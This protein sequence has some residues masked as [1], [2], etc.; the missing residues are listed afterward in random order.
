MA[1]HAP[2]LIARPGIDHIAMRQ[3]GSPLVRNIEKVTVAFL[4]LLIL[5]RGIGNTP[6]LLVVI[7]AAKKMDDD[8]FDTVGCL[9][10]EKIKGIMR[11]GEVTVHAVGH[12]SLFIVGMGGGLPGVVSE[13]N[14]MARCAKLRRGCPHHGEIGHAEKGK[15]YGNA[16]GDID[17]RLNDLLPGGLFL[18]NIICRFFHLASKDIHGE[19]QK[20]PVAI[21]NS[22]FSSFLST[23]G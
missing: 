23:A 1:I 14:L 5:E 17:G 12:K 18:P 22:F 2:F 10:I 7:G 11:C 9:G 20:I 21:F 15:G 16:N 6:L 13:L 8:V 4:A 19:F 3:H